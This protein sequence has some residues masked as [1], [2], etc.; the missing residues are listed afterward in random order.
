MD[1]SYAAGL[2]DADGSIVISRTKPKRYWRNGGVSVWYRL[3]VQVSNTHLPV[4]EMLVEEYGGS[5]SHKPMT[6][7]S[8][9]TRREHYNW[10]VSSNKAF[11][12]LK[13]IQ[14]HLVIKKEQAELGM[15]FWEQRTDNSGRR[16]VP[17]KELALREGF[18]QAMKTLKHA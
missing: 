10:S 18:Y 4:L 1:D 6:E 3:H 16:P 11:E 13:R 7:G 8:F 5:I 15:E 2:I 17:S 14:P 12:C 9:F